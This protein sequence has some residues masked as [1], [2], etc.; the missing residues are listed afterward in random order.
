MSEKIFL[1]VTVWTGLGIVLAS[2]VEAEEAA[3]CRTMHTKS[4]YNRGYPTLVSQEVE[5]EN[6]S[7][8][9]HFGREIRC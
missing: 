3:R 5:E 4:P 7:R 1:V 8:F 6:G 2:Q 9:S